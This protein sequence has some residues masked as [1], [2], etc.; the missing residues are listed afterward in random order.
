MS[1]DRVMDRVVVS[2]LHVDVEIDDRLVLNKIVLTSNI[3]WKDKTINIPT[4]ELW[5]IH[6]LA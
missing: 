4:A 5:G 2:L 3:S 1:L 6:G